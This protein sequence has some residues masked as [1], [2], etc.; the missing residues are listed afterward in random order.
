M[1][2]ES[3]ITPLTSFYCENLKLSRPTS[4]KTMWPAAIRGDKNPYDSFNPTD[5]TSNPK[6]TGFKKTIKPYLR[7]SLMSLLLARNLAI[8]GVR[9][10]V[11]GTRTGKSALLHKIASPRA[12][13]PDNKKSEPSN[14]PFFALPVCPSSFTGSASSRIA[15]VSSRIT[16]VS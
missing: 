8:G 11:I 12:P 5:I 6:E 16:G 10:I 9:A 15:G 14:F 1:A 13:P 3:T 4:P 2:N 7:L